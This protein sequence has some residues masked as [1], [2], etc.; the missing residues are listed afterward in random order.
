MSTAP[1]PVVSLAG[2]KSDFVVGCRYGAVAATLSSI[3]VMLKAPHVE[4]N[5]K[6]DVLR[7]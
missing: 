5:A 7:T 1:C 6:M 3:M 4:Y 2:Y